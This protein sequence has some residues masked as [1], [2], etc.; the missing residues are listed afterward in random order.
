MN[1]DVSDKNKFFGKVTDGLS[2]EEEGK[3]EMDYVR[4]SLIIHDILSNNDNSYSDFSQLIDDLNNEVIVLNH[5]EE[6]PSIAKV[7]ENNSL[8]D[9]TQ[10]IDENIKSDKI[11]NYSNMLFKK[12]KLFKKEN[13][14][15]SF[16]LRPIEDHPLLNEKSQL[17]INKLLLQQQS[18]P[19]IPE[20]TGH[21][22]DGVFGKG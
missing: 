2:F 13:H 9:K 10:H 12:Q 18:I 17:E 15:N 14:S 3:T 4:S 1:E 16:I 7:E 6:V 19:S 22:K 21:W 5:Q 11:S 20:L 8:S